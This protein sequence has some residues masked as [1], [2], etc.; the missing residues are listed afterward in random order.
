VLL[1]D[2]GLAERQQAV[3]L[4]P[5]DGHRDVGWDGRGFGEG[6]PIGEDLVDRALR[7]E[8][9]LRVADGL[10]GAHPRRL[11]DDRGVDDAPAEGGVRQL[12]QVGLE[13]PGR[14]HGA[15]HRLGVVEL[16][17]RRPEPGWRQAGHGPGQAARGGAEGQRSAE[18]VPRDVRPGQAQFA[19]QGFQLQAHRLHR[20][21]AVRLQ[22]RRVAVPGQVHG[23]DGAMRRQQV[24]DR[25][26]R[27]PP[28][29]HAVQQH[30][31][32]PFSAPI[33]CKAHRC[34][35]HH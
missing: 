28:V 4:A 24:S 30:K 9:G 14:L 29:P 35:P 16:P 19:E 20:I 26:P 5:G 21:H 2:A 12:R 13:R 8:E 27:L 22:R 25:V 33:V 1:G 3:L 7:A 10:L 11:R 6:D 34:P 15:E 23:D 31:L 32:R 17:R 18:R